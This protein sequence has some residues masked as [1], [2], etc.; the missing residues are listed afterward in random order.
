M[1]EL[2][3]ETIARAKQLYSFRVENFC[4]MGNHVHMILR[5]LGDS[6]LSRIMQWI[7]SVFA[8]RFNREHN[9]RGHVWYDRFRSKVIDNIRQYLATFEYVNR[10]PVRA[11]LVD[12][13]AD[14]PYCGLRHIRD[15]CH[16]VVDPPDLVTRLVQPSFHTTA[17]A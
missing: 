8:M 4:V 1:K 3:L 2:L 10:N 12:T 14:Y 17:L 5:P 13:P 9:Y 7:L 11:G 6:C 16:K 15:G